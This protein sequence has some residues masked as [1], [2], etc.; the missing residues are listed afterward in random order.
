M[1]NN[2]HIYSYSFSCA[3][4]C[5]YYQYWPTTFSSL[6]DYYRNVHCS[7]I[8]MHICNHKARFNPHRRCPQ[9]HS[10]CW[11]TRIC[12]TVHH[13]TCSTSIAKVP[14]GKSFKR[15]LSFHF[16]LWPWVCIMR[17]GMLQTGVYKHSISD[18]IDSWGS[19]RQEFLQFR[20]YTQHNTVY[21][22]NSL[23]C[24]SLQTVSSL[25]V[26]TRRGDSLAPMC[27]W[28]AMCPK[29]SWGWTLAW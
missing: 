26:G 18:G 14:A 16:N 11:V 13:F 7:Y 6:S 10:A 20:Q 9:I 17:L 15:C 4:S 1:I 28:V 21:S 3:C 25:Q 5:V 2:M 19:C 8:I 12:V 23:P 22:Y 27:F 29:Q 24:H